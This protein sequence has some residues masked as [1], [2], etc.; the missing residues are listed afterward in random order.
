MQLDNYL[1]W[2][3]HIGLLLCKVNTACSVIR[4][5][6]HVLN[7]DACKIIYFAYFHSLIECDVNV[8]GKIM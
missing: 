4:R 5:L 1:T 3:T 6:F 8:L 7:I 2:R